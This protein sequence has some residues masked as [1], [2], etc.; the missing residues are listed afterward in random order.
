MC[1]KK[2][3]H[4]QNT[5][6]KNNSKINISKDAQDATGLQAAVNIRPWTILA[7]RQFD[8]YGRVNYWLMVRKN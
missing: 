5:E 1:K 8:W 3:N 7:G 6:L 4:E 2:Q